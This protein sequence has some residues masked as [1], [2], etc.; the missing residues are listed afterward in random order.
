M[1]R[2]DWEMKRRDNNLQRQDLYDEVRREWWIG[3][4]SCFVYGYNLEA[5]GEDEIQVLFVLR[6][7]NN[8]PCMTA[9]E[10]AKASEYRREYERWMANEIDELPP[11]VPEPKRSA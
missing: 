6:N 7:D 3:Q 4:R 9:D 5:W 11:S 8:R 10:Y 1:K 2:S